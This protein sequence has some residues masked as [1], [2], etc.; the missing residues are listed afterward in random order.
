MRGNGR[1]FP[2]GQTWWVAYY[3][4]GKEYR[5]STGETD[6]K[7]AGNF[8]KRRLKEV[9]ADQIGAATFITPQCRRLTVHDL[10]EMV[11]TK[12]ETEGKASPQNLSHL[13]RADKDFGHHLAMA[14]TSKHV[15]VYKRERLDDGD[16]PASINRPLQ[17]IRQAYLLAEHR[18]ELVRAPYIELLSED[19]NARQGFFSEQELREVLAHL[20]ADLKDFVDFAAATGMRKNELAL[21][22]WKMVHDDEIQIPADITKNR[23]ARTLPLSTKLAAIIER[24]KAVRR[25]EENGTA[26]MVEFIFH[27]DGEPV[28]E[29]RKSWA[30][31]CVAAKVGSMVCPKCKAE[32]AALSCEVCEV[33]TIYRGKIFHDLR[34]SAVRFMVKAGVPPQVAKKLSGHRS[35]AVFERYSIL[36][37]DDLRD[38]QRKTEEYR[39]AAAA[40][41]AAVAIR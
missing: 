26:R 27:R 33:P 19:G 2:R 36:N 14:L 17:L 41:K 6:E 20:P 13:R 18:R 10:L 34:R 11:K 39:E 21:L 23:K 7:K 40:Q 38:G 16:K 5:E 8:L 12:F 32:G 28:R 30:R 35:D 29:F 37:T 3:L 31:A 22:T 9:G 1:I 25:I 4:R 24:R 15:D